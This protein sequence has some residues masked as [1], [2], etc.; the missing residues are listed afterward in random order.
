MS[1]QTMQRVPGEIFSPLEPLELRLLKE[2][3]ANISCE[4][5]V[6][7]AARNLNAISTCR[8]KSIQ[9]E[10]NL[11]V[12]SL[13]PIDSALVER[14]NLMR[15]NISC[16]TCTVIMSLFRHSQTRVVKDEES[17]TKSNKSFSDKNEGKC[18]EY[19]EKSTSFTSRP[20]LK[21]SNSTLYEFESETSI[22]T[23]NFPQCSFKRNDSAKVKFFDSY[24]NS[25]VQQQKLS[26]YEDCLCLENFIDSIR[27]PL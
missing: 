12:L 9:T 2:Q 15:R 14:I 16:P 18:V 22:R 17:E 1:H 23:E 11:T 27:P 3:L 13:A 24:D 8:E 6:C 7:E 10:D 25:E 21:R 5:S 4:C 26:L 20:I 19:I